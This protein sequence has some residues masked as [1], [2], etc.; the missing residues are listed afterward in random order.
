VVAVAALIASALAPAALANTIAVNI[1]ADTL[2]DDGHCSLREAVTSANTDAAS[3][4]APGECAAGAGADAIVLGPG[5]YALTTDGALDENANL[6][7]DLDLLS[8]IALSGSGAEAT[9][10]SARD[11][12]RVIDIAMGT[13]VSIERVTI[14]DGRAPDGGAGAPAQPGG[15]G[16][17]GGGIRNNAGT[18][19]VRD[20]VVRDN[21]AGAGGNAGNG[22]GAQSLAVG[23]AGGTGGGIFSTGPLTLT[24]TVVTANLAGPGGAAGSATAG[25][26]SGSGTGAFAFGPKGGAGGAGGGVWA[27]DALAVFG[28]TI[29]DNTGGDGGAGGLGTG[30]DGGSLGGN[31]GNGDGGDGGLGGGGGGVFATGAST[32]EAT[33]FAGNRAGDGGHGG[34]AAGGEGGGGF[35]GPGARG[36]LASGGRAGVGGRG[37][38]LSAMALSGVNLTFERNAAG[39][40]GTGGDS[41]G[42]RGGDGGTTGG[43]GGDSTVGY[44]GNGG[45]GGAVWTGGAATLNH[46]TLS[47]NRAGG[48]GPGTKGQGGVRGEKGVGTAPGSYGQSYSGKSGDPGG[49][50]GSFSA[51]APGSAQT[52]SGS[53]FS[54]NVPSACGFTLTDGGGNMSLPF[55]CPGLIADP[56]LVALAQNGGPVETRALPG[57]SPAID[58]GSGACP[59]ADARGVPR[60]QGAACDP[61]AYEVAAPAATT[62]AASAITPG[63]ATL[64][65]D[66]TAFGR[67]TRFHFDFGLTGDYGT[68]T[69]DADAGAAVAPASVSAALDGLAAG[70]TYHYRLV[71][72]SADGAGFGSD[73]AFTTTA[74]APGPAADVTA[75]VITAASV[76]PKRFGRKG[77]HFGYKLS[78][79]ASVAF[80]IE[81]AAKGRRAGK[82]CV[83]PSRSNRRKRRCTRYKSAGA[84]AQAGKLGANSK[85][86]SG[87]VRRRRLRPAPY[88][89][90]LRAT[91][92]AG[93]RSAPVRLRCRV[94]RP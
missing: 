23:G 16:L 25:A 26:G 82:K 31:G 46:A 8:D 38:G 14:A 89:V 64:S 83:K 11:H 77:T 54:R 5:F 30:G 58:F 61:G 13:T 91:D 44:G 79:A 39:T 49:G 10:I 73:Q 9:T 27:G 48:A 33:T 74:A 70:T 66:V 63:A 53:I 21:Q 65:G 84:L 50:G 32:V 19:T 72:A 85:R 62:G 92:A 88:R 55:G 69:P 45:D 12:D 47:A 68:R 4:A 40:G 3:G 28:S 81:R 42:G 1:E 78:E 6:S 52:I 37:G 41:I 59:A 67:A 24:N 94:V 75:P 20:C 2:A 86:F 15:G 22:G 36:G 35:G 90:T 93:N 56:L 57:G 87:R 34:Y 71:A 51:F 60:P 18:L 43:D 29:S 7:G 17:Q 80:T 76:T